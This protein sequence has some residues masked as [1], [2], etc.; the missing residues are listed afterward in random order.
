MR[1]S[2]TTNNCLKYA[3][4]ANDSGFVKMSATSSLVLQC[5]WN[6]SFHHQ[7]PNEMILCL[8]VSCTAVIHWILCH[9]DCR[10]IIAMNCCC[11]FLH[12]LHIFQ[13]S[14]CPNKLTSYSCSLN[15]LRFWWWQGYGP[16]LLWTPWNCSWS[17]SDDVAWSAFAIIK[18]TAQSL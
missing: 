5:H 10:L 14:S 8:S 13:I 17:K 9:C 11:I 3:N 6:A 16:L 7:I 4:F 1:K 2:F 15:V 12:L 18:R